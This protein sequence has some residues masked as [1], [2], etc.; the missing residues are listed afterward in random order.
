MVAI[1]NMNGAAP[2][3]TVPMQT[4]AQPNQPVKK[5]NKE[6]QKISETSASTQV[7]LSMES[8]MQQI[9]GQTRVQ[10]DVDPDS[11][12]SVVTVVSKEDNHV[13]RKIPSP[14]TSSIGKHP[15]GDSASYPSIDVTV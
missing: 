7:E 8:K 14:I 2:A 1:N 4:S 5:T 12:K 13:I 15:A 3:A 10:F 11:G 6:S 9:T